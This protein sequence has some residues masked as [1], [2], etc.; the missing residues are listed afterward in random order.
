MEAVTETR[1][2]VQPPW[3]AP[4]G[5]VHV[6]GVSLPSGTN[7]PPRVLVGERLARV[8]FASTHHLQIVVPSDLEGGTLPILVGSDERHVGDVLVARPLTEGL[9]QVDNPAFDGL[10]RL[11]L[12]HSGS[13]GAKVPVNAVFILEPEKAGQKVELVVH[14]GLAPAEA[15]AAGAGPKK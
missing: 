15:P 2:T 5:R 7:R 1:A 13:R 6:T 3:V 11:Y 4:G 14:N 9:H 8:Q 10:G 12:T